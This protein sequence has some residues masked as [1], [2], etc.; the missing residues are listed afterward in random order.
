MPCRHGRATDFADGGLANDDSG[1]RQRAMCEHFAVLYR[2]EHELSRGLR[3][4]LQRAAAEQAAVLICLDDAAEARI[5]TDFG[6]I[7]DRFTFTPADD[8]YAVPG[9]AMVALDRF[10]TAAEASGAPSAW[11]IGAIPLRADG[12]DVRWMLYEQAVNEIFVDRPLR[13][14]C[15]YD[16]YETPAHLRHDVGRTHESLIG[17]WANRDGDDPPVDVVVPF[18]TRASDLALRDPMPAM[19]RV[20]LESLLGW[21]VSQDLLADLQ[22]VASELVTNAVLHGAAPAVF[23]VWHEADGCALRVTDS[24]AGAVD[25]YAHFRPH[26]GGVHGGFGLFTVG[27]IADSVVFTRQDDTTVVSVY[28]ALR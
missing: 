14:V 15:L 21:R 22:I 17:D 13:A 10:V 16:A 3:S 1:H 26:K 11:S 28:V 25:Q 5:R 23:E 8:R 2:G 18:P 19:A 9:K 6:S 7:C 27:Q 20:A 4:S 24:G 12:R